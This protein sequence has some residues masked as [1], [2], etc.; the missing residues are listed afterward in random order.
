MNM[1]LSNVHFRSCAYGRSIL[2]LRPY[3]FPLPH[4][5]YPSNAHGVTD[6]YWHGGTVFDFVRSERGST[7]KGMTIKD[8][9]SWY[10]DR[11][12]K[13]FRWYKDKTTSSSKNASQIR[14]DQKTSLT[15][16]LVNTFDRSIKGPKELS[17][18]RFHDH[19]LGELE[20]FIYFGFDKRTRRAE[21]KAMPKHPQS[22]FV[23]NVLIVFLGWSL[24]HLDD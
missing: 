24:L 10:D 22:W 21:A 18:P 5:S 12:S 7:I 3:P 9:F 17:K 19:D 11:L 16:L 2:L 14:V 13:I 4:P 6:H 1:F 8:F 15:S 20:L 23:R